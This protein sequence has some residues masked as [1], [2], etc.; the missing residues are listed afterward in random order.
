VFVFVL[1]AVVEVGVG[2]ESEVVC[3]FWGVA[4]IELE[5]DVR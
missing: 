4:L 2:V 1:A 3:L 5:F